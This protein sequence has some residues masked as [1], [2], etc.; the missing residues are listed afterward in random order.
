MA[1]DPFYAH[2]NKHYTWH[3]V[4]Q[5]VALYLLGGLDALV[6]AGCLR[7]IWVYHVTWFVNS[8]AHVWGYQDYRTGEPWALCLPAVF[9][10]C[11]A[12]LCGLSLV[13]ATWRLLLGPLI[14]AA[15]SA[16]WRRCRGRQCSALR[17]AAHRSSPP[18]ADPFPSSPPH[19]RPAGDQSRNNWW[20]GLLGFGEGWHNN[21]H[22]F[23]FS[24]RHGL[25]DYQ[26]DMTWCALVPASLW[27]CCLLPVGCSIWS[28]EAS[29]ATNGT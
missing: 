27:V 17:R 15:D 29:R 16:F 23:E 12:L 5:F 25:E 20:V 26:W 28:G 10:A 1:N 19:L 24:A 13:P 4:G 21:H 6:W 22:A 3:V 9:G 18:G 11:C 14:V 7:I 2:L 8:A